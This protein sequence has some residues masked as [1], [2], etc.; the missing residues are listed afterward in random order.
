[1]ETCDIEWESENGY[2]DK[3]HNVPVVLLPFYI[4]RLK[5]QKAK[6]F[7]VLQDGKTIIADY[8]SKD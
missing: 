3:K 2:I 1:M 4:A 6:Y 8:L 7:K 5:K